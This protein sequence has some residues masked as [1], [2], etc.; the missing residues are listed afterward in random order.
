VRERVPTPGPD[1]RDDQSSTL[2]ESD[3]AAVS[4]KAGR[5]PEAQL[6]LAEPRVSCGRE[7]RVVVGEAIDFVAAA[8]EPNVEDQAARWR[9]RKQGR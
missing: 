5:L 1:A 8:D 6:K 3:A 2:D 9:A 4:R 7:L